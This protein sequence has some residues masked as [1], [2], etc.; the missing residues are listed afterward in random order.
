MFTLSEYLGHSLKY[1]ERNDL[2]SVLTISDDLS[3]NSLLGFP[4]GHSV[5]IY[6]CLPYLLDEWT[7]LDETLH[8]HCLGHNECQHL[9]GTNKYFMQISQSYIFVHLSV[10]L[11]TKRHNDDEASLN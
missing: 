4:N 9:Y 2:S 5:C 10:Q 3:I 6:V 7:N 11:S 8:K 1:L